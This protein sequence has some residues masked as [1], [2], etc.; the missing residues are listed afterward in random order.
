MALNARILSSTGIFLSPPVQSKA[1]PMPNIAAANCTLLPRGYASSALNDDHPRPP[2]NLPELQTSAELRLDPRN[3]ES[4]LQSGRSNL[5]RFAL[6]KAEIAFR[7]VLQSEPSNEAALLSLMVIFDR[8]RP[9]AL[10]G[11]AEEAA[12][13]GAGPAAVGLVQAYA[14]RRSTD[15]RGALAALASVPD[16]YE[17]AIRCRLEAQLLDAVGEYDAAF[18][19]FSRMNQ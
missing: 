16:H 9:D 1:L 2:E 15:Y 3:V 8:H 18:D 13:A 7:S 6:E 19:A 5:Q 17:P 14:F 10:S 12:R 11:L 4:L